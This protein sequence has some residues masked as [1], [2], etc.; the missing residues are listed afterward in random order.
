M[1]GAAAVADITAEDQAAPEGTNWADL[2]PAMQHQY[3]E[4][5]LGALVKLGGQ[6]ET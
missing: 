6:S 5:M 3:L 2:P 4:Q 1:A